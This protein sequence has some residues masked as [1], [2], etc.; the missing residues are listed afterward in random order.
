MLASF[1][2]LFLFSS[3]FWFGA[4]QTE[5]SNGWLEGSAGEWR[6]VL[7]WR[8]SCSV[9]RKKE[10]TGKSTQPP[11]TH[12]HTQEQRSEIAGLKGFQI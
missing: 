9:V 3:F 6:I 1:L 4:V 12:T 5:L 10:I 7:S 2:F 8:E 11:H